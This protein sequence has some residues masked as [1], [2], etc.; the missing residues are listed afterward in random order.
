[1]KGCASEDDR[2]GGVSGVFLRDPTQFPMQSRGALGLN[3]RRYDPFLQDFISRLGAVQEV[4][5]MRVAQVID[6]M[7]TPAS[8]QDRA[9]ASGVVHVEVQYVPGG[10]P[11]TVRAEVLQAAAELRDT[12]SSLWEIA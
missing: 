1:M 3:R 4:K 9:V 2:F 7:T 11:A 8:L 10:F 6:Y 5:S 12:D